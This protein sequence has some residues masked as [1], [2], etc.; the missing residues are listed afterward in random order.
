MASDASPFGSDTPVAG[1]VGPF[2]TWNTAQGDRSFQSLECLRLLVQ[3]GGVFVA[4]L[5]VGR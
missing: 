2:S 4:N 5:G 3:I 1:T